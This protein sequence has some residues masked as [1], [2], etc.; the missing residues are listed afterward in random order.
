M[1]LILHPGDPSSSEFHCG[2]FH[3]LLKDDPCKNITKV[4][5]YDG[6]SEAQC[7]IT[8]PASSLNVMH[9]ATSALQFSSMDIPVAP[10]D[11]IDRFMIGPFAFSVF[12][13]RRQYSCS[14]FGMSI[15]WD[16]VS[17]SETPPSEWLPI[18]SLGPYRE[19]AVADTMSH[20]SRPESDLAALFDYLYTR[21]YYDAESGNTIYGESY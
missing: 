8:T 21:G 3:V 7:S 13:Q 4:V 5:G 1:Y 16:V 12:I 20:T 18:R 2:K 15:T 9:E 14:F 10:M 11:G 17:E 6:E 19:A